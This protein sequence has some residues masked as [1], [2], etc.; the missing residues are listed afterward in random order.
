MVTIEYWKYNM[1]YKGIF[2]ILRIHNLILG[3]LAV[4]ISG[5]LLNYSINLLTVYSILIVVVVMAII[6]IMNDYLDIKSDQINHPYRPLV[7]KDLSTKH[8]FYIISMLLALLFI[9]ITQI[10]Y[11]ALQ[12]LLIIIL[13][14]SIIYNIYLK[15][16]PLIGNFTTSILLGSIFVFSEI[17]INQTNHILILPFILCTAFNFLREMIKDMHDYEGDLSNNYCTAPIYFGKSIMNKIIIIYCFCLMLICLIPYFVF[18]V[19]ISFLLL[20]II[21]IEIP[22][23]YS[24]FLLSKF[25][26]KTTYKYLSDLLKYLCLGGLLIIVLTKDSNIY[27]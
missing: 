22:L 10:N 25:P 7:T 15:K 21:I 2:Q 12:F 6:Y 11:D 27:V 9:L 18:Q 13:P 23:L 1:M 14:L 20:L 3:S 26:N 17:V 5:Y 24:V 4:I 16:I 19:N 8:I